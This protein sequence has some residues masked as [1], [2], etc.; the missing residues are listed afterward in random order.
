MHAEAWSVVRGGVMIPEIGI[1][2]LCSIEGHAE[3]GMVGRIDVADLA[4]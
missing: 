2:F 3:A 1:E 4:E